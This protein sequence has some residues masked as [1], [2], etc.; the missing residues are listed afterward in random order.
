VWSRVDY[1]MTLFGDGTGNI[2]MVGVAPKPLV[3]M[4]RLGDEL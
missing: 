4:S 1:R 3:S 2:S